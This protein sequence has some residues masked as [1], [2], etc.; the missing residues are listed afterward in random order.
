LAETVAV[1]EIDEVDPVTM[2]VSVMVA[3]VPDAMLGVLHVTVDPTR[4]LHV[5]GPLVT[6]T[7]VPDVTR[8]ACPGW[9][10]SVTVTPVTVAPVLLVTLMYHLRVSLG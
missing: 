3:V 4:G 9:I 5:N 10:T 7:P 2:E 6:G 1:F 8:I